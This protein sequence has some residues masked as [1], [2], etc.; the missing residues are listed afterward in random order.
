MN[1]PRADA[2]RPDRPP[3]RRG[4]GQR[5][6]PVRRAVDE[7]RRRRRRRRDRLRR[8]GRRRCD[9]ERV[10]VL[11]R[12]ASTPSRS[13]RGCRWCSVELPGETTRML[14]PSS[15]IWSCTLAL[16]PCA[17]PD[18]EDHRGDAD[19]DAEH[20]Q[21]RA[22]PVGADRFGR[23][24]ERVAPAHRVG[25]SSPVAR[26]RRAARPRRARRGSRSC[27]AARAATSRSCVISTIVRPS[28]C[29]SS[30]RLEHVGGRASSRGCR[31]ARRRG[32]SPARSRAPGRSATRCCWPPDSSP[33]RW[34]A[35]SASPTL[36]SACERALAALGGVDAAR[37]RAAARRCATPAGTASRLN[38]WNT[39]P[40]KRLRTSASMF[41]SNDCDVVA[42]EPEHA[43]R[44]HVEAAE[45]VHQRRL[46]RTRRADDR[47]E[48]ALVDAQRHASAARRPRARRSRRP[49]RRRSAR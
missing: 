43:A 5:R 3:A 26:S 31:S 17:E 35:R 6:R 20:R 39:N 1:R 38:C 7:R 44:R 45:D 21:R 42:G 40:M 4:A 16:A 33:G 22:Q 10:G 9:C 46:A 19:E 2:A 47:D 18:G 14:V 23:G 37:R 11:A 30:S 34:S 8:R 15:L 49:C 41:S 27:A 12:S 13:R 28:A 32:S 48:L 24:A 36:S 29:S 25:S